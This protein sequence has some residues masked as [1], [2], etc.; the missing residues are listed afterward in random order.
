M[1][2]EGLQANF[3]LKMWTTNCRCHHIDSLETEGSEGGM[4]V[5]ECFG[6]LFFNSHM[7][8]QHHMYRDLRLNKSL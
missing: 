5:G 8:G 4:F 2:S 3:V 6:R 7:C 1:C